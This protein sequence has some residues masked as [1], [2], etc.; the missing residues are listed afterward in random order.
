MRPIGVVLSVS[1]L[2]SLTAVS[3]NAQTQGLPAVQTPSRE[4]AET[5]RALDGLDGVPASWDFY[6]SEH[7][8]VIHADDAPR[9]I[10]Q[11]RLLE[12]TY[13]RFFETFADA[14]FKLDPVPDPL[15]G[16]LFDDKSDY[17]RYA[18]GADRVDMSWTVA[19][20]SAR[21]NRIAFYRYGNP[22]DAPTRASDEGAHDPAL[23]GAA[24]VKDLTI[25]AHPV[26]LASATHEAAHQLAF[27][28]GLQ[29]RGVMYP[30]WVSE[31]LATNFELRDRSGDFGPRAQNRDRSD[32]LQR[33]LERDDLQRLNS[34]VAVTHPPSGDADA[35]DA[36]YA[37]AWGLFRFLY[38]TR[39]TQL[40]AYMSDLRALPKG[41]RDRLT[42]RDEFI[43]RFGE[44]DALD[45]EWR[46]WIASLD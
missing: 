17:L 33:L 18:R 46:R 1:A 23:F 39:P 45:A 13:D 2:L 12:L 11:A 38:Q 26:S 29:K 9:A 36:A 41:P 32:R 21:T 14:G 22:E 4:V 24:S 37:Q 40:Q 25:H 20:Y 15:V 35:T 10:H 16:L 5:L 27:N 6:Q 7:F 30:L 43:R 8:V 42:L 31:G 28:S 3:T 34:F 19:Y 44:L